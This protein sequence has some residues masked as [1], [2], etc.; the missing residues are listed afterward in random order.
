M[1]DGMQTLAIWFLFG[2]VWYL[3]WSRP[4]GKR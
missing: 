1:S 4:T 3:T 2:W